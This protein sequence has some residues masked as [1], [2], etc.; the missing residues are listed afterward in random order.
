MRWRKKNPPELAMRRRF[1]PDLPKNGASPCQLA[2]LLASA[3]AFGYDPIVD[4]S[5]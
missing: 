1:A 2:S 3:G 5:F 4:V